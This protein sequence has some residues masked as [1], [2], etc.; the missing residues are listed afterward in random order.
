MNQV[1]QPTK[2]WITTQ[3]FAR[4][5]GYRRDRHVQRMCRDGTILEFGFRLLQQPSQQG[6]PRYWIEVPLDA[7]AIQRA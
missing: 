7:Q 6:R 2:E 5:W 3:E 1:T 4:R